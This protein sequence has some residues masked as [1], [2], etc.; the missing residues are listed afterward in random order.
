MHAFVLDKDQKPLTPCWMARARILLR[1]GRAAVF[2]RY[3]FTIILKEKTAYGFVAREHRVKVDPGSRTTGIAVVQEA[4]G[5]IVFAAEITHRGQRIKAALQSRRAIRRSRRARKTRY[6]QPRFDNRTRPKR[7]LPPS[8]ESRVGNV[9][10]WVKRLISRAPVTTLSQELIKFDLQA[11]ENPEIAGVE[12]QQGTLA[13]Y[14]TREYLLEKWGRKCAYCGK[15]DV[16]L[17]IDH[18]HPKSKGGTDRVRNLT[19]A[20]KPCNDAKGN[21]PIEDFLEAKPDVL[22]RIIRQAKAPLRDATAVNA[23]RWELF[24]RLQ[25][26]GF[27]VECGSGGR[28]KFNRVQQGFPKAHWIDAACVGISGESV[29]LDAGQPFLAIQAM[30][31]GKRLIARTDRFGFPSR[32]CPRSKKVKGFQTGDFV[33]ALIPSGKYAGTHVGRVAVRSTGSFQIGTVVV[34]VRH[35]QMVQRSDGY[36][37]TQQRTAFPPQS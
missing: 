19:L 36:S 23:T 21:G 13:G 1:Q 14:E 32:W 31:R 35:V 8:L 10:T 4:T 33:R 28:T 3:P 25:A 15:E 17:Q 2:R 30:G 16:P 26:T 29:R 22:V 5:K 9:L 37:Y 24:R 11:I 34:N 7:W 18:I 6:R 12:Y 20:C 27:P